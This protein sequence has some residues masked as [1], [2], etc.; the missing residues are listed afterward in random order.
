MPGLALHAWLGVQL[1]VFLAARVDVV[2]VEH[3]G[4][5]NKV[6]HACN[7]VGVFSKLG[8]NF[9]GV[10]E[11]VEDEEWYDF[12][13]RVA[14]RVVEWMPCGVLPWRMVEVDMCSSFG[15]HTLGET[16]FAHMALVYWKVGNLKYV[17]LKGRIP[18]EVGCF[19]LQDLDLSSKQLSGTIP[20]ELGYHLKSLVLTRNNLDGCIP[21]QLGKISTLERLDLD[22][23]K[24][25]GTIPTELGLLTNLRDLA[26]HAN[27]LTGAVPSELGDLPDLES[28]WLL[29]NQVRFV[30][31]STCVF[32]AQAYY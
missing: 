6:G 27:R 5:C 3:T 16:R 10:V 12:W 11:Y 1:Q 29:P 17:N 4:T 19:D 24:L 28:C 26:L 18:T 20:T 7:K 15:A 30:Y 13:K 25:T 14:Q 23:N 32:M 2:R 31:A 21:T 8:G 9:L 22:A